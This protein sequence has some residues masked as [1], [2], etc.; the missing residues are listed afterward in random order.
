MPAFLGYKTTPSP[1]LPSCHSPQTPQTFPSGAAVLGG[2]TDGVI[3]GRAQR[4]SKLP[5]WT[6]SLESQGGRAGVV[7][8]GSPHRPHS[9]SPQ[10]SPSGRLDLGLCRAVG[11]RPVRL[12]HSGLAPAPG[13]GFNVEL[14]TG[15]CP[16]A[17]ALPDRKVWAEQGDPHSGAPLPAGWSPKNFPSQV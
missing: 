11:K 1:S 17:L 13:G 7:D 14:V 15:S 4:G 9:P 2:R 3:W 8:A 16:H 10:R 5:I 6:A 12:T